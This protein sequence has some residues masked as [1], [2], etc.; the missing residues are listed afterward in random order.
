MHYKTYDGLG[1]WNLFIPLSII[2]ESTKSRNNHV[3]CIHDKILKLNNDAI[4][5]TT[6]VSAAHT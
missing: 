6:K 1:L 4:L 5:M 2:V 3:I